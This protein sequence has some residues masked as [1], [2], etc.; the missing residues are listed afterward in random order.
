MTKE[1]C[2]YPIKEAPYLAISNI[3][4]KSKDKC[5]IKDTKGKLKKVNPL[6]TGPFDVDKMLQFGSLVC[7]YI[8][9][10]SDL[11]K[12]VRTQSNDLFS[13]NPINA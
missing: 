2:V 3:Y 5:F 4:K 7:N 9:N 8:R 6:Y 10:I 13:L 11:Q 1:I 12:E